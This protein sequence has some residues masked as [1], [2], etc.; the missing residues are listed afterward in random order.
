MSRPDVEVSVEKRIRARSM[1]I[2][3]RSL[4]SFYLLR[5]SERI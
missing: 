2:R 4:I 1:P 3:G 5:R